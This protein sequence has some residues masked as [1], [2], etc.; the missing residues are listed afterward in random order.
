MSPSNR[1]C[2]LLSVL[3]LACSRAAEVPAPSPP[4]VVVQAPIQRDVELVRFFTGNTEAVESVEI[5]ARAQG[6]LESFHFEPASYVEKG[7]L[8]FKIEQAPYLAARDQAAADLKNSEALVRRTESD[9]ERLEQAV[10]TNA[11]SQQEVT[12]ATA[13]RDQARAAELAAKAKLE[14]AKIDLSYTEIRAPIRGI[15]SRQLVDPGNL[16]GRNDATLLARMYNVDPIYVYFEVNE[17]LIASFV[18]RMGGLEGS[19]NH[20]EKE[21]PR[22]TV[23]LDQV[24]HEFE[25]YIDYLDPAADPDTGTMQVRARVPNHDARLLPG[26]FVRI[27]VPFQTVS[28]ALLVPETALSTDLGGRYLMLVDD[29]GVVQKRY[30]EPGQLEPDKMR[31]IKDGLEAGERFITKGLQRARPGMPVEITSN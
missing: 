4:E 16:V 20:S 28:G 7:A 19:L 22:V 18:D 30:V 1:G 24:E 15:I 3:L 6:F 23:T 10:Q 25:G 8:L 17:Q 26:Y 29:E 9:L 12:R 2:L 11:V 27:R 14:Q 5:R 13:E 21:A 31:V